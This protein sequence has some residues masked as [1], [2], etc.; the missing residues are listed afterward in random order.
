MYIQG[1]VDKELT[2]NGI[3][4]IN[5]IRLLNLRFS[6]QFML[7]ANSPTASIPPCE[8]SHLDAFPEA[9]CR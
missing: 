3:Q 5:I 1:V 2:A 7:I 9:G 6:E 4:S 8:W